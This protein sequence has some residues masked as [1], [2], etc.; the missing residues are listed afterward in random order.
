MADGQTCFLILLTMSILADRVV[1]QPAVLVAPY[2]W[3][4]FLFILSG[5][6]LCLWARSQFLKKHTSLS[7]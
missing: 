5:I 3:M 2:T 7:L 6:A 4:G 1:P